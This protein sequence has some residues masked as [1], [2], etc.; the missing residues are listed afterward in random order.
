MLQNKARYDVRHILINL[1]QP[2]Q[3]FYIKRGI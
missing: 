1:G 2:F 3:F